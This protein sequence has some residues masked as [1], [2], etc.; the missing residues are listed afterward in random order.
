MLPEEATLAR[1]RRRRG[2]ARR[3]R[4]RYGFGL[5]ARL[6]L[7]VVCVV[8]LF[9]A[10]LAALAA[11]GPIAIPMLGDRI[12]AAIDARLGDGYDAIAGRTWVQLDATGLVVSVDDLRIVSSA[13]DAVIV[14]PR[15]SVAIDP[16]ALLAGVVAPTRIDI[17][18]LDIDLALT[19]DGAVAVSAGAGPIVLGR[20]AAPSSSM[21]AMQETGGEHAALRPLGDAVRSVLALSLGS[22]S[23]LGSLKHVGVARGR[24]MFSDRASGRTFAFDGFEAMVDRDRDAALLSVS[25]VGPNG[26]WT[27]T[28][29]ATGELADSGLRSLD[30]EVRDLSA[31]EIFLLSG[32][33]NPAVDFDTPISAR[34]R[35][36]LSETGSFET[37]TGQFSVG[38]GFFYVLNQHH[39][40]LRVDE[41]SGAFTWDGA[42]RRF[43]VGPVT[44]LAGRTRLSA[45]G[46]VSPPEAG[47][48]F[49]AVSLTSGPGVLGAERPGERD[50]PIDRAA[51]TAR[52]DVASKTFVA[53][54][55]E[56]AGPGVSVSG[57]GDGRWTPGDRLFR[58]GLSASQ[59]DAAA[60]LRLW[61]TVSAP[62]ARAWF[63]SHVEAGRLEKGELFLDLGEASL[64]AMADMLP[65]DEN[66]VRVS[67]SVADASLN[68]L[69]GVPSVTG[70]AGAGRV[71]ARS[72]VFEAR[73]GYMEAG[74]DRRLTIV[75]GRFDAAD[76]GRPPVH[77]TLNVRVTGSM[78]AV[79]DILGREGMKPFGGFAM[80]PGAFKG[81]VD[82]RLT[83]D[84]DFGLNEKPLVRVAAQ[85]SNL[86]V[87]RLAGKE[88]LE[89][90]A[91]TVTVDPSGLRAAGQGR[92]FGT[93]AKLELKKPPGGFTEATLSLTLD[94]SARARLG[95]GVP[96]F[97][98]PV[99]ARI[100]TLIGAGEKARPAVELDL[101]R[102]AIGN[103][104][105]GVSKPSGRPGK[106]SFT[107]VS[108]NGHA[109]LQSF[110]L[111]A[112]TLYAL[113]SVDLDP[114]GG[115]ASASFQ[116]V[117]L[118]SGDDM[119][120]EA[121]SGRDGLRVSVRATTLDARPFTQ[122]LLGGGSGGGGG[123]GP[124]RGGQPAAPGGGVDLD[125]RAALL[126]GANGQSL[127]NVE[128]RL[129]TRGDVLRDF[130]LAA[131][132][133]RAS[134][135]GGP[136]AQQ[137]GAQ[138][139]F[140][141]RSDDAGALLS[142]LDLYRRMDG[143]D[144]QLTGLSGG[145]RASGILSVRGFTLRNE[146]NL[147]RL[148]AEGVR[149]PEPG[150][151][152]I[153]PNAV[154]FDRMQ[155]A[156]A[157]TGGRLDLREGVVSGPSVGATIEGMI[158]FS[159]DQVALNGTFVPIYGLNN[160]FSKIPLFGPLLGGGANEGLIGINYRIAG[161]ATAPLMSVNPL[162]V[163]TPGFL[164]KIFGAV[165]G[166]SPPPLPPEPAPIRRSPP[167]PGR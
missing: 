13:G 104:A 107:I 114:A 119:K 62:Y 113:G 123:P 154:P 115:F 155:V 70:L 111:D 87:E 103:V 102:A 121:A 143:G 109:S 97:T 95:W 60:V 41:I 24:L 67:F 30:V 72:A 90:G 45:S 52:V 153:D 16:L 49:W 151:F 157:R 17:F 83:V 14:A 124:D 12:A 28:A 142:F 81:S 134:V 161:P 71:S 26:R 117:R 118:S 34:L 18:D 58:L 141:L 89:Q 108:E 69:P 96:G 125:L 137:A 25:G 75:D 139:Q 7:T 20:A 68:F 122:E 84:I 38:S 94:E 5:A 130:R 61:P 85:V 4:N 91:L 136:L 37:A 131:R 146:A 150:R 152:P 110:V 32:A 74:G 50:V 9:A 164:R 21:P 105:P 167:A 129:A 78:D 27:V 43:D 57:S 19:E 79:G 128:L 35:L 82:G 42:A 116:Q 127:S 159:R 23:P 40:P 156:F 80:E 92:L 54:R 46:S 64:V 47:A 63:I 65:I 86:V 8:A 158:D 98:G 76:F 66:A 51:L 11:R 101:T 133:G 15:A 2:R 145:G 39:E 53:D 106:A 100:V 29:R 132:S 36:G 33:R 3:P 31:D 126:T 147:Q 162:S 56:V 55:F 93:T 148:V 140:F 112:G 44:Y 59:T 77:G 1:I 120:V 166:Q 138:Q 6:L 135:T 144:L 73:A 48:G 10:G 163:I 165:D 22:A 88:R 160:L 149:A 99:G